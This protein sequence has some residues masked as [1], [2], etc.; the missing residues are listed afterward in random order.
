MV[1]FSSCFSY[2]Q[3]QPQLVWYQWLVLSNKSFPR[4]SLGGTIIWWKKTNHSIQLTKKVPEFARYIHG[5]YDDRSNFMSGTEVWSSDPSR[6]WKVSL[7]SSP[8]VA[9]VAPDE[10]AI[11]RCETTKGVISMKMQRVRDYVYWWYTVKCSGRTMMWV[12]HWLGTYGLARLLFWFF[13][14]YFA[15]MVAEWIRSSG[16]TVWTKILWW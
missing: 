10:E 16:R 13:F 15:A 5:S 4:T 2:A 9:M 6:T 7:A 11:V 14:P 8:V 1:I 3:F 12:I